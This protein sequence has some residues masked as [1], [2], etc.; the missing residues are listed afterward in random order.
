[1]KINLGKRVGYKEAY[2]KGAYNISCG[3]LAIITIYFLHG[4]SIF[5]MDDESGKLILLLLVELIFF[6]YSW[7]YIIYLTMKRFKS[8][9]KNR[10]SSSGSG[11]S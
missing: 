5:Y 3:L 1:M 7:M 10:V 9:K 4:I 11:P 2:K 6:T 8:G